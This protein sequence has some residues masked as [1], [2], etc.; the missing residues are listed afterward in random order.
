MQKRRG[1]RV[2]DAGGGS[3]ALR[4]R[5][6]EARV[7]GMRRGVIDAAERGGVIDA[8]E[9]GEVIDTAE[10]GGGINAT[11]RSDRRD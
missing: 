10:R 3:S 5:R 11:E 4:A 9:R 1:A 6:R 2:R 8:A 7:P